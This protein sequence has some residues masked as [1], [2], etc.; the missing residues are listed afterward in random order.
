MFLHLRGEIACVVEKGALRFCR[1]VSERARVCA[2]LD[3]TL[4]RA[5]HLA[6]ISG[7]PVRDGLFYR[8]RHPIRIRGGIPRRSQG[9]YVKAAAAEAAL[10]LTATD[11][12][13]II[14]FF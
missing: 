4:T 14:F 10:L 5:A 9:V 3:L 8:R 2:Y 12:R 7:T 11:R 13:Y 6:V 1:G